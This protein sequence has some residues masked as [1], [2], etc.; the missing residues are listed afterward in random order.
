MD[1]QRLTNITTLWTLV[2]QA[3]QDAG[4]QMREAQQKLLETYGGAVRRYLRGAVRDEDAAAEL[5]QEFAYRFLHGDLRNADSARGR[6]RDYVRAVLFHLVADY[7]NQRNRRPLPLEVEPQ[8]AAQEAA[9]LAEADRKFLEDWRAELLSRAW[10][11]LAAFEQASGQPYHAVLRFRAD[12]P[13][14][15]SHQMAERLS[16][17]L[18]R[19]LTAAGVRQALHRA[20]DKFADLLVYEVRQS[21]EDA[22]EERL[23]QELLDLGLHDYCRAAL[24]RQHGADEES[25]PGH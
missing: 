16:A 10:G 11:G 23:E 5:F 8:S 4:T 20:R 12:H 6:F 15:R 17:Q 19:P 9:A 18:G 2:R 25:N 22:T 21:L 1:Q 14:L 3:H 7:H 24:E 13:E